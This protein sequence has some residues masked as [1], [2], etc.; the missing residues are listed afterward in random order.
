MLNGGDK[1]NEIEEK[2]KRALLEFK[3]KLKKEVE[4]E[5]KTPSNDISKG[6]KIFTFALC[7]KF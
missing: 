6:D 7:K 5:K 1:I 4:K 3:N 2:Y